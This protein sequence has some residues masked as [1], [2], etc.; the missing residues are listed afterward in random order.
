MGGVLKLALISSSSE[1]CFVAF[2][3]PL[4]ACIS[5]W[6]NITFCSSYWGPN[7]LKGRKSFSIFSSSILEVYSSSS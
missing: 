2:S 4:E 1:G 7:V 6:R 3:A 5:Q